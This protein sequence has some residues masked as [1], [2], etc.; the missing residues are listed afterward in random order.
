M[1]GKF[2][3][4]LSKQYSKPPCLVLIQ[5]GISIGIAKALTLVVWYGMV[6]EDQD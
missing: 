6:V 3:L 4:G 2:S 1:K 5:R